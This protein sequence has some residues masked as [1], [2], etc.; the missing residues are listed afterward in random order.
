[1]VTTRSGLH[2]R[3][4]LSATLAVCVCAAGA[5]AQAAGLP[6]APGEKFEY[7][8]R[9]HVGVAA[10]GTMRVEGPTELRGV[11]TWTLHSDMEGKVG[12]LR[13]TDRSESWID[14]VHMMAVRYTARERHLL[15]RHDDAVDIFAGEKRWSAENGLQGALESESPL[16]ELSFL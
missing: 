11:T 6:F 12:F 13:A 16:D 15:A 7:T 9:V 1:M 14:P 10:R 2:V 4:V 5:G 8:G 3:Q